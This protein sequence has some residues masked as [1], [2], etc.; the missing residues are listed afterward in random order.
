MKAVNIIGTTLLLFG[1][2]LIVTEG[3][4]LIGLALMA[5]AALT[6]NIKP[7]KTEKL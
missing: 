7:Y 3:L 2:V 6:G 4:E 5:G 1:F